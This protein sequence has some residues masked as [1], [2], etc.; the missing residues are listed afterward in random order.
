MELYIKPSSLKEVEST[1]KL[2][3]HTSVTSKET[4]A[5][6][7]RKELRNNESRTESKDNV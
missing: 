5:E 6:V 7:L 3:K 2:E 4:F 1:S